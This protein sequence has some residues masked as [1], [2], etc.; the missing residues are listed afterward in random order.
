[1][2]AANRPVFTDSIAPSEADFNQGPLGVDLVLQQLLEHMLGDQETAGTYGYTE[3]TV[4]DAAD[5]G[6]APVSTYGFFGPSLRVTRIDATHVRVSPGIGLQWATSGVPTGE[7]PLRVVRLD[8]TAPEFGTGI[9]ITSLPSSG[10]Y[11]RN[12]IVTKWR[13]VT[14]QASRQSIDNA[15]NPV[16]VTA[17]VR[18]KP[19]VGTVDTVTSGIVVVPGTS[20]SSAAG[21]TRP[22]VPTGYVALAELLLDSTGLAADANPDGVTSG[23]TDL[24]ARLR[25]SKAGGAYDSR[26]ATC[27]MDET[28]GPRNARRMG[29]KRVGVE[30]VDGWAQ[31]ATGSAAVVVLDTSRDWRDA[32]VRVEFHALA[33]LGNLPGG[34]SA[35]AYAR[36]THTNGSAVE[37]TGAGSAIGVACWY[38]ELGSADGTSGPTSG[39]C[40]TAADHA[41]TTLV[42]FADDATGALCCRGLAGGTLR[43]LYFVAQLRGPL[44][45]APA[46]GVE[47]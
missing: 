23:I 38:S 33:A 28:T 13:D 2:T 32:M 44:G 17:N 45:K 6:A 43:E 10:Q 31:I 29:A 21:A 24:R 8:A 26:R 39:T 30:E 27:S 1:M 4:P 7:S 15:G 42:F 47:S 20:A 22:A 35:A 12:L 40:K 25:P 37:T 5:A 11:K 34:A 46:S 9:T 41:S 14:V 3:A 18:V 16:S 36:N 19:E